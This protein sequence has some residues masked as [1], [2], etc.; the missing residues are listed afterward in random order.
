M[1][2][3]NSNSVGASGLFYA[4]SV[5]LV[6]MVEK[7]MT[8]YEI[9]KLTGVPIAVQHRLMK[10]PLAGSAQSLLRVCDLALKKFPAKCAVILREV[11]RNLVHDTFNVSE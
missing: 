4:V 1:V 3:K 7:E 5:S 10:S 9:A 11:E 8:M 6:R 2:L